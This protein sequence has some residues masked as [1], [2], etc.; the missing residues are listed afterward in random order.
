MHI[1]GY[2][3]QKAFIVTQGPLSS[4]KDDFWKMFWEQKSQVIVML[5]A[6]EEDGKVIA[7]FYGDYFNLLDL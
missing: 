5:T 7:H 6:L 1:Q 4:T 2:C 3:Q